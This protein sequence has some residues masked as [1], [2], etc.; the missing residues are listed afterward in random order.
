[1][2]MMKTSTIM[3]TFVK[4]NADHDD[5]IDHG[6]EHKEAAAASRNFVLGPVTVFSGPA[7]AA[8]CRACL[9]FSSVRQSVSTYLH[10]ILQPYD[11]VISCFEGQQLF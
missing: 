7:C 6:I 4:T 1:M 2:T 10:D 3:K 9:I 5:L 11:S 8:R